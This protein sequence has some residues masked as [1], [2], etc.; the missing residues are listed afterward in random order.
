VPDCA[1]R[2]NDE[3]EEEACQPVQ[4]TGKSP[5]RPDECNNNCFATKRTW[6]QSIQL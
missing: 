3:I 4:L 2:I 6:K 1:T 5:R